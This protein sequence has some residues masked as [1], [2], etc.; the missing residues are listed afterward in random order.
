M[1]IPADNINHRLNVLDT[2]LQTCGDDPV[3]GFFRDGMCRTDDTDHGSHTVCAVVTDE[4]LQ[5]SRSRGNDLVT[6]MPQYDFPGLVAGDKWCLCAN[7]WLE[8]HQAGAAPRILLHATHR[9][10][11]EIVDLDTLLYY[12]VDKPQHA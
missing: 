1:E 4:F 7:R 12:A 3:T 5:Y 9:R 10:T 8:A 6:P 2:A 11:L